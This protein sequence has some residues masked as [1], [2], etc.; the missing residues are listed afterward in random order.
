MDSIRNECSTRIPE[1]LGRGLDTVGG[2]RWGSELLI[3]SALYLAPQPMGAKDL[4]SPQTETWQRRQYGSFLKGHMWL[5]TSPTQGCL[6]NRAWKATLLTCVGF[7]LWSTVVLPLCMWGWCCPWL[8]KSRNGD[9]LPFPCLLPK[10]HPGDLKFV[11]TV[12]LIIH[13][14]P[15]LLCR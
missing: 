6:Q 15:V 1:P 10:H 12:L 4:S 9:V 3:F 8:R 5:S 13:R 2:G 11:S 14:I 7:L